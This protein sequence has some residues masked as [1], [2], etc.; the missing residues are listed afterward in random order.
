MQAA[1][2]SEKKSLLDDESSEDSPDS[3]PIWLLLGTKTHIVPKARLKPT[4][5]ILP[6]PLLTNSTHSI[7]LITADPQRAYKDLVASPAFPKELGA[8]ITKVVGISKIKAKFS[9]YEAQRK[10][11]A[12]HDLFLADERVITMLPKALGKTFYKSTTKRPI[13]VKLAA[14]PKDEEK[15]RVKSERVKAADGSVQGGE[16]KTA[17]QIAVQIEKA[18]NG[19]LV[20]LSPSVNTS[21]KV[22]YAHWDAAKLA[23][24][25]TVVVNE[26]VERVVV[27]KWRGV[28]SFHVKGPETVAL[29]IWLADELWESEDKIA[30]P[31]LIS[32]KA[33]EGRKRKNMAIESAAP[34]K[35][36]GGEKKKQKVKAAAAVAVLAESNDD[37]LDEEIKARKELLKKQ[38]VEAGKDG[39]DEVPKGAGASKAKAGKA[40]KGKKSVA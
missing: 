37:K 38:K 1:A 11:L 39:V 28:R 8:R 27:Q 20:T 33:N 36:E 19:T 6:H 40:K 2:P 26:L 5:I 4:K 13:P 22:G 17:Q 3:T 31:E 30:T 29:P 12:E 21:I 7:C 25:I 18:L 23:E 15:K 16:P 10:L 14:D 24:N 34:E 9:Q 35:S 32:A